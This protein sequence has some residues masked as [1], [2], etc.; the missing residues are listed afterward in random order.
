MGDAHTIVV[1]HVPKF[2]EVVGQFAVALRGV[3]VETDGRFTNSRLGLPVEA[4][5]GGLASWLEPIHHRIY[6]HAGPN[7]G[8]D[9]VVPWLYV[10]LQKLPFQEQIQ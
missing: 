10:V 8:Q 1:G 4:A 3:S 7:G 5:S 9:N 6:I 2:P